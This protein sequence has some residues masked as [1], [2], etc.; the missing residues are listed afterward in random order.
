MPSPYD[1][2]LAGEIDEPPYEEKRNFMGAVKDWVIA[3]I[4]GIVCPDASWIEDLEEETEE[5]PF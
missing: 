1:V 4:E 2:W 5:L 3:I